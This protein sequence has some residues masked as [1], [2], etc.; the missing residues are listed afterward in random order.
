V[1]ALPRIAGGL[2]KRWTRKDAAAPDWAN[3]TIVINDVRDLNARRRLF[4]ERQVSHRWVPDAVAP[5]YQADLESMGELCA[6]RSLRCLWISQPHA[7]G[8]PA[9]PPELV[10]R[11]WMN[12]PYE[13][14][15][16]ELDAMAQV[17]RRY[18]D[19]LAGFA[20]RRGQAFCDLATGIKPEL[21]NFYDD[22]HFT[23]VGAARVAELVAACVRP[24]LAQ[25][26][27]RPPRG[28][29]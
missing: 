13:P 27:S 24:L 1:Q 23:D 7:Y 10:Q 16:I 22:M 21:E 5:S 17:A 11:L 14:Y 2:V 26:S 25:P 4:L 20:R 15:G 29:E 6:R 8:P 28:P 9:P 3:Q 12:P 19:H 18:N